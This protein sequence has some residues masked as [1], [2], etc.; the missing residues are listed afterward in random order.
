MEKYKKFAWLPTKV[1]I[2]ESRYI[3]VYDTIW[4]KSYYAYY[5]SITELDTLFDPT[6]VGFSEYDYITKLKHICNKLM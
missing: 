1:I 2:T 5:K 6:I 4:F 3:N